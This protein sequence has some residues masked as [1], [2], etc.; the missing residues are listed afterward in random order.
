MRVLV[1]GSRSFRS[2]DLVHHVM[3]GLDL[4]KGSTIVHGGARG[5]DEL[6]GEWAKT[7]GFTVEVHVPDW[8]RYGAKA[9]LR[10]NTE[11][12]DSGV[13][14]VVAFWDS[15]SR[16]TFDT[17]SKAKLRELDVLVVEYMP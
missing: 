13:K 12:L 16:G 14:K 5:A 1:C 2:R 7:K 9:G 6:A 10:R 4:V 15:V 11:M 8:I 3:S 17:I